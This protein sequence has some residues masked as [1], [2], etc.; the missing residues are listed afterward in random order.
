M[1][2][3]SKLVNKLI[4]VPTL[5]RQARSVGH[6][7]SW[8][9][10]FR[11]PLAKDL[12]DICSSQLRML[13]V[14]F[15]NQAQ[16]SQGPGSHT[17]MT[18]EVEAVQR[19]SYSNGRRLASYG[20]RVLNN[21]G[22]RQLASYGT[23]QLTSYGTRQLASYGTRQ[24]TSYG[25]RQLASYGTRQLTSYGT[26]QLYGYGSRRSLSSYVTRQLSGHG[27]KRSLSSR[28]LLSYGS[29][30]AAKSVHRHLQ[31]YRSQLPAVASTQAA[32]GIK[33]TQLHAHA[34]VILPPSA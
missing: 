17:V 8:S 33:P 32:C 9:F 12:S 26:R 14:L 5:E 22:S 13:D 3:P 4:A 18:D 25:T 6:R 16:P 7:L 21:Y 29:S 11:S 31:S 27:S 23:R 19:G 34:L 28:G 24:L 20:G 2:T 1:F 10:F 30:V 15:Q